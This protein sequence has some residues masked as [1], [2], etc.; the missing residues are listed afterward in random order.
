MPIVPSAAQPQENQHPNTTVRGEL[1]CLL[2]GS[3]T[4][5]ASVHIFL[6][7]WE[8]HQERMARAVCQSERYAER[9]GRLP[10]R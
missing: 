10:Q 6:R 8:D 9:L 1:P 7:H 3:F 2:R 4:V 5:L